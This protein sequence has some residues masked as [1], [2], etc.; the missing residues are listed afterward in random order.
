MHILAAADD[1]IVDTAGDREPAVV[2]PARVAGPVPAVVDRSGGLPVVTRHESWGAYQDLPVRDADLDSVHGRQAGLTRQLDGD[3]AT[4]L[5]GSVAVQQ[6]SAEQVHDHGARCLGAGRAR[7]DAQPGRSG[8]A[9]RFV[10]EL[11]IGGR[12]TG[13]DAPGILG[14]QR[15]QV[16]VDDPGVRADRHRSDERQRHPVTVVQGQRPEDRV[17]F[18][19]PEHRDVARG[20]R[21]QHRALRGQH[22]FCGPVVP[23]V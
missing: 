18:G 21:P 6:R 7:R 20:R 12:H 8:H 5:G 1:H 17:P 11:K 3:L 4:G 22:S 23:E 15:G 13:E 10:S 9:P 2:D 19:Q 14:E 16:A